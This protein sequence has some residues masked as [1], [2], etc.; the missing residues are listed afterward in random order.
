MASGCW[1]RGSLR[2][3][4]AVKCGLQMGCFVYWLSQ[5][6][7]LACP[8]ILLEAPHLSGVHTGAPGFHVQATGTQKSFLRPPTYLPLLI[9]ILGSHATLDVAIAEGELLS[10]GVDP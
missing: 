6:L 10:R 9:L 4:V 1:C 8:A 3:L 7:V 5:S 2:D